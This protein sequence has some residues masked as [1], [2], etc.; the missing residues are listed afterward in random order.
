MK[1]TPTFELLLYDNTLSHS[2]SLGPRLS[3]L[4]TDSNFAVAGV[5][6]LLWACR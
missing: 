2:E 1:D 5:H 3:I 6:E 4:Y